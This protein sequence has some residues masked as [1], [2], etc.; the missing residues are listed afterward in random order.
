M[1]MKNEDGEGGRN[2]DL[3][4]KHAFFFAYQVLQQTEKKKRKVGLQTQEVEL[5]SH[6]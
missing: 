5:D 3:E 2:F 1:R 4:S 6:L